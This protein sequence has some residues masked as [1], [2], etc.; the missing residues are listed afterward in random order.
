MAEFGL[1]ETA[2]EA[3]A[4][5]HVDISKDRVPIAMPA[6]GDGTPQCQ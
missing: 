2:F 1:S 3:L 6:M 4:A 5:M